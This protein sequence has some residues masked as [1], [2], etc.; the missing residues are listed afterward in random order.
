MFSMELFHDEDG[1]L[2]H[3]ICLLSDLS[4]SEHARVNLCPDNAMLQLGL[5]RSGPR[6][7]AA[8]HHLDRNF[9]NLTM[10]A[11][12]SW[13]VVRGSVEVTLYDENHNVQAIRVLNAGDVTLTL[14]GGHGYK[15]LSD[16]TLVYEFKSGPYEG[17]EVDKR[18]IEL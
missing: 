8:H 15:I 13:V 3:V 18:L 5:I 4:N 2:N 6:S 1:A 12:E 7:Y 9:Q 10:R 11:Q 14:F 16:D 17:P